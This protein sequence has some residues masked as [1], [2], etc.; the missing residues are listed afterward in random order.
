MFKLDPKYHQFIDDICDSSE[1]AWKY[2]GKESYADT[3]CM[4]HL[5]VSRDC[6]NPT[7]VSELFGPFMQIFND[8]CKTN[9]IHAE[10]LF[11]A[12]L[13]ATSGSSTDHQKF[14]IDFPF[15]H[16]VMIIYMNDDFDNGATLISDDLDNNINNI[17]DDDILYTSVK[18]KKYHAY[19]FDGARYHAGQYPGP[20]QRRV[21][22]IFTFI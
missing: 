19:M 15:K 11:G 14:H 18:A 9:N 5:L 16:N 2:P 1:I 4:Y 6:A 10:T 3:Q 12:T 13:H 22:C 8:I 7:I 20:G 21:V 17:L